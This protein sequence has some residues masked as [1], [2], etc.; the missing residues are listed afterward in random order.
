MKTSLH[1]THYCKHNQ[2]NLDLEIF[3]GQYWTCKP[4]VHTNEETH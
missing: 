4:N 3:V 1:E 2:K